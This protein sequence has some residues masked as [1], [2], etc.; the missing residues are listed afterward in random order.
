MEQPTTELSALTV[1][2]GGGGG[3]IVMFCLTPA[4]NNKD[5]NKN[6]K[7]NNHNSND[8]INNSVG[9]MTELLMRL[10]VGL[11]SRRRPQRYHCHLLL[12]MRDDD[13]VSMCSTSEK[14]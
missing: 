9:P 4:T 8:N 2:G 7:N 13:D 5:K 6:N 1:S 10:V 14:N 11:Q 3:G 12:L